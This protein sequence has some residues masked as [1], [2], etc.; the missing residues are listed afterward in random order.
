LNRP[1]AV[2]ALR[3]VLE[4]DVRYGICCYN[5]EVAVAVLGA[6]ADLNLSVPGQVALVGADRTHV[7]QLISP[8]LTTIDI[9]LPALMGLAVA[10]LDRRRRPG[11]DGLPLSAG[12]DVSHYLTL[13]PGESS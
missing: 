8:R 6:A 5:D 3:K 4:A 1:G 12:S 10:E 7:G 2:G 9:D 11:A 13:V